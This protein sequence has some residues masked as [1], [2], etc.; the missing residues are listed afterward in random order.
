MKISIYYQYY[1]LLF[2]G[3]DKSS[4]GGPGNM[5][6]KFYIDF[7]SNISGDD[8][9]SM[10]SYS[11]MTF[12]TKNMFNLDWICLQKPSDSCLGF[13]KIDMWVRGNIF[14]NSWTGFVLNISG[15][16]T[17]SI[18]WHQ[19]NMYHHN[20]V[21]LDTCSTCIKK[22]STYPTP[23]ILIWKLFNG[24]PTCHMEPRCLFISSTTLEE[25]NRIKSE[26]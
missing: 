18:I 1:S 11:I 2:F 12:M 24:P 22:L 6:H 5:F 8:T 16:D 20:K 26:S 10:I 19:S 3:I 23:P 14:Y 21:L 25:L 7:V 9:W 13:I 17:W 15:G 4:S